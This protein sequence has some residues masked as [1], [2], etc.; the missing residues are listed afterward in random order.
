MMEIKLSHAMIIEMGRCPC[1][2][3]FP[4]RGDDKNFTR[5]LHCDL[6]SFLIMMRGRYM[7]EMDKCLSAPAIC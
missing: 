4:A 7:G 1:A 3:L 6:F 5:L 2:I